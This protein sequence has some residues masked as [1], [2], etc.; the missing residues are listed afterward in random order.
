MK[1]ISDKIF[2]LETIGIK[3]SL[4]VIG[5]KRFKVI[6]DNFLT[7]TSLTVDSP[8]DISRLQ[9]DGYSLDVIKVDAEEVLEVFGKENSF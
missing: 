8:H 9:L 7:L 5:R 3:P 4:L 1:E 6:C 2:I